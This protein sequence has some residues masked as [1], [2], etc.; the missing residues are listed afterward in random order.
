MNKKILIGNE[1]KHIEGPIIFNPKIHKDD[2]GYFL[3]S[4]NQ[5]T[6]NK[7]TNSN[8]EFVQDNHSYSK[9]GVLRGLHYQI[10]PHGQGKLVRCIRGEVFDVIV[11]IR[12]ESK[13][14]GQ[15][16]SVILSKDNKSIIWIPEGFAH[17]FLTLSKYAEV[18][19]KTT[20]FWSKEAERTILWNDDKIKIK[21]P[22]IQK[23]ILVSEKDRSGVKLQ[24]LEMKLLF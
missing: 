20:K 17:G 16:A 10:K 3:E 14:F 4:W 19:Y 7:L 12:R 8:F 15:W 6:F 5:N 1:N 13:T 9:K 18:L 22:T 21:W 11:D 24:S 2:R 23:E